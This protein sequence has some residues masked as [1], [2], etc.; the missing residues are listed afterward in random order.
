MCFIR[1]H[2]RSVRSNIR[3]KIVGADMAPSSGRQLPLVVVWMRG[4]CRFHGVHRR[5]PTVPTVPHRNQQREN[6][7]IG[8]GNGS[9]DSKT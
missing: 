8:A 1:C 6:A 5:T 2:V 9:D 3:R 4:W 7:A